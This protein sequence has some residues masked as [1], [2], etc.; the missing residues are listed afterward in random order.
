MRWPKGV[1]GNPTGRRPAKPVVSRMCF[2]C[3]VEKPAARFRPD[4]AVTSG[5]R[6]YC[7][8]CDKA[9]ATQWRKDNPERARENQRASRTRNYHS[10]MWREMRTR[11]ADQ[12][13]PFSIT[14]EE[15][16][17]LLDTTPVCPGFKILLSRSNT[18]TADNSV[19]FDKFEPA[20]GYVSGNVFVI[21]WRANKLKGN[22]TYDELQ[23][24]VAW[25]AGRRYRARLIAANA[26][27]GPA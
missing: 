5:L 14:L 6:S 21:S 4:K 7:R 26:A 23:R 9:A 2:K 27:K 18:K 25:M 13:V 11:A 12:G 20:L 1:S 16:K 19:S 3:K 15:V 10:R 22:A 8:D 24:V 17:H